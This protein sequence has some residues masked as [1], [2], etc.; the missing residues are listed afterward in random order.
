MKTKKSWREYIRISDLMFTTLCFYSLQKG[1][2]FTPNRLPEQRS[3]SW[4]QVACQRILLY[5]LNQ[6]VFCMV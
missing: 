6:T 4:M 2:L 1:E 3:P 5:G